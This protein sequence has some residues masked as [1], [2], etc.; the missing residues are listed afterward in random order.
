MIGGVI[1]D[2]K[3]LRLSSTEMACLQPPE[4][5]IQYLCDREERKAGVLA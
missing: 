3:T 4:N 1:V 2:E 5:P